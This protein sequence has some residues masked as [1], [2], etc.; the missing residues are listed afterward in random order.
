MLSSCSSWLGPPC[1]QS[2]RE[3]YVMKTVQAFSQRS[4]RPVG[5]FRN[6]LKLSFFKLLRTGGWRL[7]VVQFVRPLLERLWFECEH[8]NVLDSP[9]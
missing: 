9:Y 3:G 8:V 6:L 1:L 2:E 5:D 4:K 7:N